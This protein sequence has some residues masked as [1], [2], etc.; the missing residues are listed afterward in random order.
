MEECEWT[1]DG[2]ILSMSFNGNKYNIETMLRSEEKFRFTDYNETNIKKFINGTYVGNQDTTKA[3][4]DSFNSIFEDDYANMRYSAY[5]YKSNDYVI[6]HS[7]RQLIELPM[8]RN[9]KPYQKIDMAGEDIIELQ[10][11][12]YFMQYI[13]FTRQGGMSGPGFYIAQFS[14]R[15][16]NSKSI[17]IDKR[18]YL[19]HP[20]MLETYYLLSKRISHS[21]FN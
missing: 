4:V 18:S 19:E 20:H 13:S 7:S 16:M 12:A 14:K 15:Y 9:V 6:L 10:M 21:N 11:P 2:R 1:K 3:V 8:P 17:L 5:K